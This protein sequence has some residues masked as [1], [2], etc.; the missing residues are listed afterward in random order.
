M[1]ALR[2]WQNNGSRTLHKAQLDDVFE[3]VDARIKTFETVPP[4]PVFGGIRVTLT[5][6]TVALAPTAQETSALSVPRTYGLLK[7]Q[8]NYPAR[9]RVYLTAAQ[10]DADLARP[11]TV[12]PTGDHGVVLEAVTTPT[13]LTLNLV[14]LASG[15]SPTGG[16]LAY[17]TI[18]NLDTVARAITATFTALALE[19]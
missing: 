16:Q 5:H 14:P 3:G 11:V 8:T 7:I 19:A 13:L 12:D 1:T 10:R 4:T 6:T 17:L 2:P 9:V 18:D 15:G